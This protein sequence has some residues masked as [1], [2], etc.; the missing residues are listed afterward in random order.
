[1]DAICTRGEEI[2]KYVNVS[3]NETWYISTTTTVYR[4]A[5]AKVTLQ[6]STLYYDVSCVTCVLSYVMRY[7]LLRH[8]S[9]E[10]NRCK[11]GHDQ[12]NYLL[13]K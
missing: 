6:V 12:V 2:V 11:L 8:N 3:V 10:T 4:K 5:Y 13:D 9:A 1:M 7:V